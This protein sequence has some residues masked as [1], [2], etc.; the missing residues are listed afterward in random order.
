MGEKYIRWRD[1]PAFGLTLKNTGLAELN[2]GQQK[3]F[4]EAVELAR[5]NRGYVPLGAQKKITELKKSM[6][7]KP[8]NLNVAAAVTVIADSSIS[9][10]R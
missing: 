8:M 3:I 6:G 10:G 7:L 4:E 2:D 5:R 1:N 9:K